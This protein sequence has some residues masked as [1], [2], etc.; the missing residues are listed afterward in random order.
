[1]ERERGDR[2]GVYSVG[3]AK[4]VDLISAFFSSFLPSFFLFYLPFLSSPLCSRASIYR[5]EI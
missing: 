1:M 4:E 2:E 3:I 5:V